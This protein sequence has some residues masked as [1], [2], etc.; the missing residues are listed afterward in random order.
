VGSEVCKVALHFLNGA[1]MNENIN[2]T[3]IALIPKKTA[4]SCVSDF[5]PISLCNVSYKIIAKVLANRLK[6]ILP[7]VISANQS[8]FVPGRLITDNI[9]A[10]YETL[11]SMHYRMWSKVGY[12]G[13]K[14]DMSKAYDRVEWSFLEAVMRKMD[15][16]E[17]WINLTMGC[18]SSVSYAILVN[19]QP[20]DIIKPSRGIRQ[21]DPLSPFLFLLCAE[22]LSALLSRAVERGVLTGVPTSKKG[23]R[24]SHLFF[25]DDS[26]IF[27]KANSVEWRRLTKLLDKYEAA[28]GQKLNKDKTSIFF[29]RNTSPEKQKEIALLSGLQATQSYDK[30]LGLSTLVGKSRTQAFAGIKDRVWKCIN[31][32]K[33]KFLTQAGKE[34]LIKAVA[35]A[36]LTYCMSVF[37]M[38]KILCKEIEGMMQRFWWGHKDNNSKIHWMSWERMGVSKAQGGLGFRDL[39]IFN[40]AL[41]AKQLWRLLQS[42]NSLAATILKAKYYPTS[43][44]LEASMGNRPSYIWRSFMTA[45]PTLQKGLFWRIGCGKNIHIWHDKWVPKPSTYMIHSP[46]VLLD[47]QAKVSELIDLNTRRWKAEL[48][49]EIFLEEDA[50]LIKSIP[51]SPFP[52]EDRIIWNGTKTGIFSVRSAYF[53][54]MNNVT[55]MRGST[56]RPDAGTEW[57]ACWKLNVPNVVKLFL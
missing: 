56:S 36:I 1:K 25:A 7:Y 12:M 47:N 19:G 27:C 40:K 4:P 45:K 35:Q 57:K 29:S 26:L 2:K 34:I 16:S 22:A 6:V 38:P 10:A 32:W 42:P 24:L 30:Y 14:L 11:H 23:P 54:E 53:L 13:I 17:A 37:L 48:I 41:L 5:R 18:V 44:I 55:S 9:V 31:N 15:F 8:A 43:S 3:H 33:T 51:L 46:R 28:S 21:G 39:E 49:S 52:A 20:S 50:Q